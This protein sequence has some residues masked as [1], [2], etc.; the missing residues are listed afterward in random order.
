M[1][2]VLNIQGNIFCINLNVMLKKRKPSIETG[3]KPSVRKSSF[4]EPGF[5]KKYPAS[6]VK[7]SRPVLVGHF[8]RE[9]LFR[10]LDDLQKHPILWV[11]GPAGSGK[12][13]LI[14]SYYGEQNIPCRQVAAYR[15]ESL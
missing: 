14:S 4:R 13:V 1:Y 15:T 8:R 3:A 9:R 10:K 2:N 11:S 5:K 6:I 12:S 7:I